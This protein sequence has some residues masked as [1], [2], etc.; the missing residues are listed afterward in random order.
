MEIA[1]DN[2]EG[3]RRSLA[4]Q[5]AERDREQ[6][7]EIEPK[8]H[9]RREEIESKPRRSRPRATSGRPSG[10]MRSEM[11]SWSPAMPGEPMRHPNLQEKVA[12][13]VKE[14]TNMKEIDNF[15]KFADSMS[16]EILGKMQYLHADAKIWFSDDTLPDGFS[17]KKGDMV[18]YQLILLCVYLGTDGGWLFMPFGLPRGLPEVVRSWDTWGVSGPSSGKQWLARARCWATLRGLHPLDSRKTPVLGEKGRGSDE[19]EEGLLRGRRPSSSTWEKL[20]NIPFS[21]PPIPWSFCPDGLRNIKSRVRAPVIVL[22]DPRSRPQLFHRFLRRGLSAAL[23]LGPLS[24]VFMALGV[25]DSSESSSSGGGHSLTPMSGSED[26]GSQGRSSETAESSSSDSVSQEPRVPVS[27][28]NLNKPFIAEGVPSK[29]VDKDVVRIRGRYQIPENIVLRLPDDGEWA[30]SSNGED[31]ALYED[32]LTGGLRLPFRPFEREVLHRLGISPSQLN[33]N[34]WRILTGL[35]VL[36]KMA[37]EGEYDLSVDEFFFLYKLTYMPSTPGVWGFMRHRGSPKLI[38]ELPNS[39]RSWKPKFFFLCGSHFEFTPGEEAGKLY[40][41]R[42]SWGI[43]HANAFH[44]PSLSR[45][46]EQRLSLVT[47]FQKGR[48]VELF[49][50]VS[51]V[52]LA[53]WSLGPEPSAEV[54]KAIQAYNRSMTTRA[55]RKRLRE[56]AQK[57]DDLPDASALFSKRAKS[58]KK[59]PME[60][61]TSSKKGGRQEK[62]LPAAKGRAAEKVHVYHEIPS[63]PIRALK[64]KEAAGQVFVLGNRV[65]MSARESAKLKADLEKANAQSSANQEAMETLNAERGVLKSQMKKLETDLK[66]KDGRLSALEKERDEL[67]RKTVGLQQQV[68]NARE[69]AVNEFKASEEFEDDT[70]RYYVAGFEHFR[71]RVAL[72]FGD[73]HDWTTVKIIDDEE[74]T[75]AEGDSEEEEEGDD[76]QSKEQ[77]AIPPDVPSVLPSS[78]QSGGLASGSAGEPAASLDEGA[79]VPSTDKEV[80]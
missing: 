58:E 44:R 69:T 4:N 45:R 50:L 9:W 62:P 49:D 51:P 29:L 16:E 27:V 56:A 68:L 79:T 77:V 1:R 63:S 20:A 21:C 3:P 54:L 2:R 11:P 36:W 76:V 60:K 64:G 13:E 73:A 39:N 30:C 18:A 24:R 41:L 40:G 26:P 19:R 61:G 66:A 80:P 23:P 32:S 72:A 52:T 22:R 78:D 37:S 59:V 38:L 6:T 12:Q 74:T 47:D 43:P 75:M 33:P 53:Q 14:A 34:G 31:I 7:E 25:G 70:R 67:V 42:R 35:Q 5:R 28:R 48:A 57:V 55:E 71:K 46:L 17:V 8:S 15:A 10:T 65:R